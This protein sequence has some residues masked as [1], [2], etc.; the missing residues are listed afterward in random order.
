MSTKNTFAYN[1]KRAKKQ[2]KSP[3]VLSAFSSSGA[4]TKAAVT[5]FGLD[6][7][8]SRYALQNVD[9]PTPEYL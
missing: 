2:A 3:I 7:E 8:S 9:T 1:Y 4:R 5:M 6:L